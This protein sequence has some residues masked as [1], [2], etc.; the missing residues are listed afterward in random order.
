[1]PLIYTVKNIVSALALPGNTANCR[2]TT[3]FYNHMLAIQQ[4]KK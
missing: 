2:L 3:K 4:Q 1:M